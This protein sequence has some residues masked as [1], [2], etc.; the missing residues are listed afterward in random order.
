MTRVIYYDGTNDEEVIDH[1]M[2]SAI[3]HNFMEFV[4]DR[5]YEGANKAMQ[6]LFPEHWERCKQDVWQWYD[7]EY[8]AEHKLDKLKNHYCHKDE[9]YVWE[10]PVTLQ[11]VMAVCP[12]CVDV[13]TAPYLE[14]RLRELEGVKQ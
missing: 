14:K 1:L 10:D 11:G 8:S 12:D 3:K 9:V 2:L 6:R 13:K 4:A 5:G 7:I